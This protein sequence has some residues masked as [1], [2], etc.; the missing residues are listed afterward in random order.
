MQRRRIEAMTPLF[1]SYLLGGFE[2]SSH[3]RKDG[4]RLDLL[5]GTRHDVF[6][7][8][9]YRIVVEH[10][11]RSVR[12][13][14]RWHLAEPCPG[15]YDWSEFLPL[16]R[17]AREAGVQPIWDV[18][19]YGWPD[20]IDI[21]SSA[22]VTR[23]ARFSAALATLVRDEWPEV[24]YYCPV[25][26]ISFWAWAGGDTGDIAPCQ[27]RRG[28]EL[29][30]QLV[31]AM[32]AAIEAIRGVDPRARFVAV[33]PVI[34]IVPKNVRQ[35]R[36]AENARLAQYQ[37]WDIITG[38]LMPELGGK[39]GHLDIVGVNFYPH[40]QWHLNGPTIRRG[41]PLYRPLRDILA[42]TYHRYQRP[43]FVAET[44]AEGEHRVPWLRYVCDEAAAALR[45]GIPVGGICLYPITDY[46]GWDNDRHCPTGM[47]GLANE[48]GRRPVYKELAAEVQRQSDRFE[49]LL[50]PA[51]ISL[52]DRP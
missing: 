9:D 19:H 46:P 6:A 32:V 27:H 13:G 17:A 34:N 33:D 42:E 18:C 51:T 50:E 41:E 31:R 29:K 16:L 3:R 52:A 37:A 23:F 15:V 11:I 10:G 47:L 22:F 28:M 2:C 43:L 40:N 49:T 48:A 24:P 36:R 14:I 12:D 20:D 1:D 35:K 8:Q 7:A 44:G 30:R 25:N 45:G 5:R 38:R 39:P 26:E 4:R 21:W